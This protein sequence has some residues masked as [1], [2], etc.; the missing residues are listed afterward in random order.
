MSRLTAL[1]RLPRPRLSYA[2]IASTAALVLALGTGTAYAANTVFSTD[3]VDGEVKNPDLAT[4]AVNTG[5]IVN[6][7]VWAQDVKVDSL[8]ADQLA[9]DAV[10]QSEIATDGVGAGEVQDNSIDGG[11]LVDGSITGDDV[12]NDGLTTADISGGGSSGNLSVGSLS[13]GRCTEVGVNVGGA[14]VGD[15]ATITAAGNMPTGVFVYAGEITTAGQVTIVLCNLSGAT[16]SAIS[17]MPVR[18][19]TFHA[20]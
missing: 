14:Q 17:N 19:L 2:N 7:G 12:A 5:K 18:V 9:F 13:N 4:N 20:P 16:S 10:G 6:G 15:A 11:E 8:T 1:R 3:I